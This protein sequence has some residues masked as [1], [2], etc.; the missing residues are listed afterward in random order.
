M[1]NLQAFRF[2][3]A[4]DAA[5]V[6]MGFDRIP[7]RP[8]E[9]AGQQG[10][11]LCSAV[12]FNEFPAVWVRFLIRS[13]FLAHFRQVFLP[14]RAKVGKSMCSAAL[15]VSTIIGQADFWIFVRHVGTFHQK[16]IILACAWLEVDETPAAADRCHA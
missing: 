7:L 11:L 4:I 6:V 13:I 9:R 15:M 10:H 3:P 12:L 16:G 5:K 8:R 2:F 14:I 1:L